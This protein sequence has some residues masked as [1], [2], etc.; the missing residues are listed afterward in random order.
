MVTPRVTG[1]TNFHFVTISGV[2]L[3]VVAS[4]H[5]GRTAIEFDEFA[6]LDSWASLP[7]YRLPS[8]SSPW[9]LGLHTS[10]SA[11]GLN[12]CLQREHTFGLGPRFKSLEKNMLS[13]W[14]IYTS[15]R[16]WLIH[17]RRN[18]K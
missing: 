9:L 17:G 11:D 8:T 5:R 15:Y 16:T 18:L 14:L 2:L 6:P 7:S 4:G 1:R 10:Q 13:M 12:E 3:A